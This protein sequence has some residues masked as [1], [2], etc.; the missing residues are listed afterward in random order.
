MDADRPFSGFFEVPHMADIA[1][2]V[3][4]SNLSDLFLNAANGLYHILGIRT[5]TAEPE[6][7]R[8]FV[9]EA[10]DES[11]LVSFLNELL[12][13]AEQ[14]KAA[15]EFEINV[16]NHKLDATLQMIPLIS[17]EKEIKAVTYNEI[18]IKKKPHGFETRLVFDI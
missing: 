16:S 18:A 11:L 15:V 8:L 10:D 1:I 5:G 12:Y 2:E 4:A 9:E 3:S 7:L 6:K 14:K 13:Y 17:V